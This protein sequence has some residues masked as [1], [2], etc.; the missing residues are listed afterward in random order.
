MPEIH[1]CPL[2]GRLW[3]YADSERDDYEEEGGLMETCIRCGEPL[4]MTTNDL[5]EGNQALCCGVLYWQEG[6]ENVGPVEAFD[7]VTSE[8]LP[9]PRTLRVEAKAHE[10]KDKITEAWNK[11]AK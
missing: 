2:Y 8:P 5:M 11:G 3:D 6:L 7:A 9:R 4:E 1:K 10:L